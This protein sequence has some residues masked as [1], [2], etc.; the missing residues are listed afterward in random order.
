MNTSN[1]ANDTND[2]L[3]HELTYAQALLEATDQAMALDDNVF[4]YGQ[5]ADDPK[6]H[7]ATTLNLHQKYGPLRCFDTPL[8]EEA[9]LGIGIGAAMAGMRPINI[10]QRVDFLMV[11]MNQLVNVAA[12]QHYISSGKV[13]VPIVIRACIGRS[14][15]QGAQHSQALYSMFA[16]IPGLKVIAP[17]T[18]H[19][20][21]A[22]L[23]A[24]IQDDGPVIFIEHRLLYPLKGHV[25]KSDNAI[26]L[27]LTRC[28]RKGN[29]ITVV[30][31]SHAAIEAIRV[32]E[33]LAPIGIDAEM[34]IPVSIRPV[35]WE[36]IIAS[37]QKTKRMLIIDNDWLNCGFA[38]EVM[39]TMVE[40]GL[41][42]TAMRRIGFADTPCPTTHVLEDAFYPN[43]STIMQAILELCGHK[44]TPL[45][46]IEA[47]PE[48]A[49]F[50]GPF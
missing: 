47:S 9:M 38:S 21:K 30:A 24:A 20:A 16:H 49:A 36:P 39:A 3:D 14:W 13:S 35:D 29:D 8:A 10:H 11:C 19:D 26:P 5:G 1:S 41:G 31:C 37:L 7:Y 42:H 17:V 40:V 6:G 43:T 22:G 23:L 50:R 34:L 48:I 4:V 45:P 12:K 2:D 44:N 32:C 46:L 27:P 15:G 25:Y 33:A 18:A 28:V